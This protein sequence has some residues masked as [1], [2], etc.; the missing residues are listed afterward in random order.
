MGEGHISAYAARTQTVTASG[1]AFDSLLDFV[2]RQIVHCKI[3]LSDAA[4]FRELQVIDFQ[5]GDLK[6]LC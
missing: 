4:L 6:Q 3:S 1:L 5:V 2:Y